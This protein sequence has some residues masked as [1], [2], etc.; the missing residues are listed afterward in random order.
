MFGKIKNNYNSKTS[1]N[2]FLPNF[3]LAADCR[4]VTRY[5]YV[6]TYTSYTT[7]YTTGC[8]LWSRCRASRQVK[9]IAL[10]FLLRPHP[11]SILPNDR[12]PALPATPLQCKPRLY[13]S[14]T[15]R[16]HLSSDKA[17]YISKHLQNSE[18]CRTLCSADCIYVLD[19]A[20]SSFHLKIKKAIRIQRK[21]PS[22]NQ[23]LHQVNLKLCL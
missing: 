21:Q 9:T 6:R 15:D 8:G 5:Y 22:L 13:L 12:E 11:F 23:Q 10:S 2:L 19:H 3:F 7:Y 4:L 1:V 18:H 14:V 20:C 16:E 17:S